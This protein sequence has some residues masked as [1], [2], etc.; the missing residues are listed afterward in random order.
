MSRLWR[1]AI[2]GC[3]PRG[4]H[5]GKAY[6]AHPRTAVVG[7]CDTDRERLDTLGDLLGVETRESDLDRLIEATPDI[8]VLPVRTDLHHPPALRVLG[9]GVHLDIEKPLAT[10]LDQAD[11]ILALAARQGV[12]VAVHHQGRVGPAFRAVARAVDE[13][14]IGDLLH[15]DGSC[16]GYYGGYGMMNIGTHLLNAVLRL[17]GPCHS[18]TATATSGG[19]PV[20]P[21]DVVWA[22]GGMGAV[23]GERLVALLSFAG[24][25]TA[26]VRQQ[27]F[28]QVD[29]NA[30]GIVIHGTE[31]KLH[32]RGQ[33]AYWLPVPHHVPDGE[34][35]RWE[36]LPAEP[37]P[38]WSPEGGAEAED[39][40]FVEEYVQALDTGRD[41][42]CSG[43]TALHV[44]E[45]L[46]GMFE[47]AATGRRVEL[48]Q[49]ERAHP[50]LA[51]RR[52]AGLG[53]PPAGP[54]DY[55]EWLAAEERRWEAR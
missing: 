36:E 43:A 47:S 45:I 11:E 27:R 40:A 15:L 38:G 8:V 46:M 2:V 52:A 28:P 33:R 7:L 49:R 55:R 4:T 34:R 29:S 19:R 20:T 54:L 22:A 31:G 37:P 44:L 13:G 9:H 53:D 51:W 18:V 42:E 6:H 5:A 10:S 35:D 39:Y 14:R 25:L 21:E 17:T 41:H 26:A 23:L 1:V 50:L 32:W 16:K 30:Y 3:G 12:R 48:P 24:G